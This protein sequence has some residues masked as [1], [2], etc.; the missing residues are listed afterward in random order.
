MNNKSTKAQRRKA[1]IAGVAAAALFMGGST[2]ALWSS[3]ATVKGGQIISGN[4]DIK[5]APLSAWDVSGDRTDQKEFIKT[6]PL[7]DDDENVVIAPVTLA[8]AAYDGTGAPVPVT[9]PKGH[10]IKTLDTWRMVPG[11]TVAIAFPFKITLVGDNLVAGLRLWFEEQSGPGAK[12][13]TFCEMF[14]NRELKPTVDFQVFGTDGQAMGSVSS[15]CSGDDF[16]VRADVGFFQARNEGQESGT[17]EG[18]VAPGSGDP[19]PIIPVGIDGTTTIVLMLYINF[20]A[21]VE[22]QDFT[23]AKLV[24]LAQGIHA[25]LYQIRCELT[26]QVDDD[27]NPLYPSNFSVCEN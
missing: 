18:G 12:P 22:N 27:G 5:G 25:N 14:T 20:S 7:I 6:L 1:I 2:Y 21:D 4:L 9:V 11:D 13:T 24:D 17:W 3:N 26:E 8:G 16:N 23:G 19:M 10:L 15:L